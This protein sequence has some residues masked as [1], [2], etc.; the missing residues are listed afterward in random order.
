MA[1]ILPQPTARFLF[2]FAALT[3][4][5]ALHAQTSD[6]KALEYVRGAVASQLLAD[7]TDRSCW[8]YRDHD[9]VPG[10]DGHDVVTSNVG[11]P[12]GELKRTIERDGKPVSKS[13]EQA[14]TDRIVHFVHD[15]A[16]QSRTHKENSHDDQ[17]ATALL[18]MLPDAFLWTIASETPELVTL[19][20][21]P[22][23]KFEGPDYQAKVM[24]T[25][26][27]QLVVVRR[28]NHIK[29]FRGSLTEDFK[30]FGGVFGRLYKGGTFDVERREVAPGF[31][32]IAETHV[33][34]A[35]HVFV[36]H[37]IGEQ[38]DEVKT[39]WKPSPAKTL[40]E[41]ARLLNANP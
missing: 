14:E 11:T 37:T 7:K 17:Q 27:G 26:A 39:D 6:P 36:F 33:H 2:A 30:I 4:S 38:Q 34:I 23:P 32:E 8:I 25:M 41:A 12:E 16:A 19:N 15:A 10:R 40:A 20:Y 31:W 28:G 5:A 21:T 3:F 35:G 18:K 24:S 13:D 22:N 9:V 1:D 29:T